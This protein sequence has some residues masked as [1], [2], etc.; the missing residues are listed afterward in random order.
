MS[1]FRVRRS[2]ADM[3]SSVS[4]INAT[5]GATGPLSGAIQRR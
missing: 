4:G 3:T 5:D 1:R 2:Y